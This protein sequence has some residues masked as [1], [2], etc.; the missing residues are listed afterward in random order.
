MGYENFVDTLAQ[1]FPNERKT[2]EQYAS[3]LQKYTTSSPIFNPE[4]LAAIQ[5]FTHDAVKTGIGDYLDTLTSNS[6]L[7]NVLSATNML[8]AGKRDK[9]PLYIH[10]L[11][12]DFYIQSA[13]R[14]VGGAN[15]IA[16]SLC[17]S[18]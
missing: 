1:S 10:A 15:V 6:E 7:K 4:K 13:W 14:M 9:T 18:I 3:D 16:D 12:N 11:I 8:Y 17:K 5:F 2:L